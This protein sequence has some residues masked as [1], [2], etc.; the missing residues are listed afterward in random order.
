MIDQE[1]NQAGVDNVRSNGVK[2]MADT[3]ATVRRH[4]LKKTLAGQ[5]LSAG[6][7][8]VNR[9]GWSRMSLRR[10]ADDVHRKGDGLKGE[11]MTSGAQ[12]RSIQLI[13]ERAR[14]DL[15]KYVTTQASYYLHHCRR[16]DFG[17]LNREEQKLVADQLLLREFCHSL[18]H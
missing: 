18:L 11:K 15:A 9:D 16:T 14:C 1:Y 10:W 7:G 4:E 13:S 2:Q 12:R 8:G 17:P 6:E 3:I 5:S